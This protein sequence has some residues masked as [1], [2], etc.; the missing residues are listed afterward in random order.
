MTQHRDLD[1]M[2]KVMENEKVEIEL[3]V[4]AKSMKALE[5]ASELTNGTEQSEIFD[6]YANSLYDLLM[7]KIEDQEL[8]DMEENGMLEI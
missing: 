3:D 8:T 7:I 4:L 6:T 2:E 5:L 1:E